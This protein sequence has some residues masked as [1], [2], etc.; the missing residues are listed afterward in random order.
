MKTIICIL[1]VVLVT[2]CSSVPVYRE[3]EKDNFKANVRIFKAT[4]EQIH[5]AITDMLSTKQ[6]V[7]TQENKLQNSLVA[8]RYFSKSRDNTSVML[9][10]NIFPLRDSQVQLYLNGIQ[11]TQRNYVLDKT[12]FFLWIIPLPGGGGK[13]VSE[14]KESQLTITDKS[15]YDNI[16]EEI[17]KNLK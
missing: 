17:Q 5:K 11:T 4:T 1:L 14:T 3:I 16:F 8:T 13:Q 10:A 15:F 12:R 6:F 2:G 9:Q 7:I